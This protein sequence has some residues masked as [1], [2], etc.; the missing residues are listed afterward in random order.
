MVNYQEGILLYGG[1]NLEFNIFFNDLW[2]AKVSTEKA[3]YEWT[4]VDT[5][6]VKPTASC[7]HGSAI[8][9]DELFVLGG[10]TAPNKVNALHALNLTTLTWRPRDLFPC[11]KQTTIPDTALNW[12]RIDAEAPRDI[13]RRSLIQHSM[14]AVS[15][16]FVV[17]SGTTAGHDL[18]ST[19]HFDVKACAWTKLS[20]G[21]GNLQSVGGSSA[22]VVNGTLLVLG[23]FANHTTTD[24]FMFLAESKFHKITVTEG[25]NEKAR[26]GSIAFQGAVAFAD[27]FMVVYGGFG[28]TTGINPDVWLFI[29]EKFPSHG[30]WCKA[31]LRSSS[32]QPPPHFAAGFVAINQDIYAYGGRIHPPGHDE[33]LSADMWRFE[34]IL[35]EYGRCTGFSAA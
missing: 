1:C 6:G 11:P 8:V 23:G 19:Y 35:E 30:Y 20:N 29:W 10:L 34:G 24:A 2:Q 22:V 15:T 17:A 28:M 16:G 25:K 21:F 32:A 9:G 12:R 26:L 14:V 31:S 7:G 33:E 5:Q 18:D 4:K 27:R 3:A 13:S